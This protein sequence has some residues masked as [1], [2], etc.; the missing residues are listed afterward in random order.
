MDDGATEEKQQAKEGSE[1]QG[2]GRKLAIFKKRRTSLV[3]GW[4]RIHACTTSGTGSIPARGSKVLH[5]A[6]LD[7]KKK[8][9]VKRKIHEKVRSKQRPKGGRRENHAH[10]TSGKELW[11]K[12][13][14]Q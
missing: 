14:T 3:A 7:Q 9:F 1:H 2:K 5:A 11:A 8:N 4:L 13:R 10:V 6:H 12:G